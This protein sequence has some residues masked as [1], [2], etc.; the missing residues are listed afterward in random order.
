MLLEQ[1]EKVGLEVEFGNEIVDYFDGEA[2]G[3][4]MLKN[5][6]RLEA[7][8]VI[9]ADGLRTHSW[10]LVAGQPVPARSSGNA[11]FRV[12]YPADVAL[13]DPVIYEHFKPTD[14]GRSVMQMWVGANPTATLWLNEDQ[15]TWGMSYIYRVDVSFYPR[16]HVSQW[17]TALPIIVGLNHPDTGTAEESWSHHTSLSEGTYTNEQQGNLNHVVAMWGLTLTELTLFHTRSCLRHMLTL[18]PIAF[19]TEVHVDY[20]RLA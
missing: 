14:S 6:T 3:G 5:G 19:S 16:S 12:A 10:N 8:L 2:K 7:D 9:A 11:I 4:L 17:L 1:L 18:L 20:S 15:I 13:A